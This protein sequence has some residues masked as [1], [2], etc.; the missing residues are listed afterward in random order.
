MKRALDPQKKRYPIIA[1]CRH[2]R[3]KETRDSSTHTEDVR[4]CVFGKCTNP[5]RYHGV[6][7]TQAAILALAKKRKTMEKFG[8]GIA[9][10][11][12][13]IQSSPSFLPMCKTCFDFARWHVIHKWNILALLSRSFP[14]VSRDVW[15]H[16]ESFLWVLK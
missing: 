10:T 15:R 16:I 3:K 14:D 5:T 6:D 9:S 7:V 4:E 12:V 8:Y 11:P 1:A 2:A 13:P